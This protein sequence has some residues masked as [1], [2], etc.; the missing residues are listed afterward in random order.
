MK[1]TFIYSHARYA[2]AGEIYFIHGPVAAD[3]KSQRMIPVVV[4]CA[5]GNNA[6]ITAVNLAEFPHLNERWVHVETLHTRRYRPCEAAPT[7]ERNR[8]VGASDPR[9]SWQFQYSEHFPDRH[10]VCGEDRPRVKCTR[11]APR[12]QCKAASKQGGTPEPSEGGPPCMT[13]ECHVRHSRMRLFHAVA[14]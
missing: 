11:K 10:T 2:V 6:R 9:R 4:T 7:N 1:F 5:A 8:F 3:G 13:P 12:V 14:A